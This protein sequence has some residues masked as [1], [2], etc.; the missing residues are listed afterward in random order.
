MEHFQLTLP[1]DGVKREKR[2]SYYIETLR[3]QCMNFCDILTAMFQELPYLGKYAVCL[4][5]AS[6]ELNA[7]PWFYA[8][9]FTHSRRRHNT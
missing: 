6:E 5:A 8:P 3:E 2:N 7:H 4:E 9:V 1:G